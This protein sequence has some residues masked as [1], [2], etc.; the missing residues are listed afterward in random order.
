[1]HSSNEEKPNNLLMISHGNTIND[2]DSKN[3]VMIHYKMLPAVAGDSRILCRFLH[4]EY[5][6][7]RG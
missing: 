7:N 6:Q 1:M 4:V 5:Y 3:K 2:R